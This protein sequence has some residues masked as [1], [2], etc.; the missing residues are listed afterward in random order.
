MFI[1]KVNLTQD[2]VYGALNKD[3]QFRS[4]KIVYYYKFESDTNWEISFG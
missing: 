3:Q 2:D 4:N 1:I